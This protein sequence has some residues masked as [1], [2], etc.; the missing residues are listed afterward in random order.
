MCEDNYVMY[1][2]V[3]SFPDEE[4]IHSHFENV[5]HLPKLELILKGIW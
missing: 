4:K 1:H 3:S 5:P 2:L